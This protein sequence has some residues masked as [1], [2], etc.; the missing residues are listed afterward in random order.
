MIQIHTQW[1]YTV[2][3]V[4]PSMSGSTRILTWASAPSAASLSL[5]PPFK[6]YFKASQSNVVSGWPRDCSHNDLN[7]YMTT[8]YTVVSRASLKTS[9]TNR[10]VRAVEMMSLR[11]TSLSS[12]LLC[13]VEIF[14]RSVSIRYNITS[15]LIS[16]S[17]PKVTKFL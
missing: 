13:D 9:S 14:N 3:L 12:R 6:R 16:F 15:L 8:H 17:C 1:Q 5:C 11:P 4:F 10:R 7:C 2:H